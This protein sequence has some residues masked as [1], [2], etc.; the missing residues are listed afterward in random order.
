MSVQEQYE[1][2]RDEFGAADAHLADFV[3]AYLATEEKVDIWPV[4]TD[5]LAKR[6]A[7][8]NFVVEHNKFE[9]KEV[10]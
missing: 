8:Y 4:L 9:Q 3:S 6:Q 2:L 10:D 5:W 1:N 7:V